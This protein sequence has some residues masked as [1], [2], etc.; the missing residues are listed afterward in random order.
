VVR[1][2]PGHAPAVPP[3]DPSVMSRPSSRARL[4]RRVILLL[5]GTSAVVIPGLA[6]AWPAVQ[7]AVG[8]VYLCDSRP[9]QLADGRWACRSAGGTYAGALVEV[10]RP[11]TPPGVRPSDVPPGTRS[12]YVPYPWGPPP[13]EPSG[14]D[15]LDPWLGT[16]GSSER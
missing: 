13:R 10:A 5:L 12:R 9:S 3:T 14:Y 4:A 7:D 11:G 15:A 2:A 16:P 6:R 1:T 8:I